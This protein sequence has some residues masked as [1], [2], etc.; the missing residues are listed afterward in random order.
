[1]IKSDQDYP[2]NAKSDCKAVMLLFSSN[3][4]YIVMTFFVLTLILITNDLNI[5][6][7][8]KKMLKKNEHRKYSVMV[9]ENNNDKVDEKLKEAP[10][11][12]P[13]MIVG[14]LDALD[15]YEIPYQAFSVLAEKYGKIIKLQL[16]SVPSMV[17]NGMENIKEVLV[18]KGQHF[19][20]RPNFKRY[21]MLFTLAFCDWSEVQRTRRDM[22]IPHTFPRKFSMNFNR[23]SDITMEHLQQLTV[24]IK[25]S[26]KE[27]KSVSV[28]PLVVSTCANIFTEYFTSRNFDRD[29]EKFQKLIT[30]FDKIFWEV[31]QGYASDFLPFLLPLRRNQMKQMEQWSHE[32]RN[33][34]NEN[35]ITDRFESW[36][37]GDEPNDY[38]DS[39][40][41]HVKQKL[42][43]RFEWET[44]REEIKLRNSNSLTK[45][46]IFIKALFALE[47]IIGGHSAVA[48]FVVKV[49]AFIAK[50]KEV[51]KN[52]QEEVDKLLN[53]RSEHSVLIADRNK[54][55][56]TE[57]VIMESLRIVTSPIVPHVANQDSSI[58]G[59]SVKAGTLIFLNNYDLNMSPSLWNEPEKFE[60]KRFIVDGRLVKPDHFI[61]FGVGR[62]SC[63]GYKMVQFLSFSIVANL[64]K[65]F[66]I[67]PLCN[68]DEIKVPV[69]SLAMSENP[70]Q[71]AF[72]LRT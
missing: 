17:I 12:K 29:N 18:S 30:N 39:L 66:D 41:D 52:I 13:K 40:I 7:M 62:R 70:Y 60:P 20:S 51:Q 42:Q 47:D 11:P 5:S 15:G 69:G 44:V 32:I 63:M 21:H 24:E 45:F 34:I 8:R 25:S 3:T 61:P 50:H 6:V 22:L 54:L 2:T 64:L 9:D 59:Y 16:G 56:Y 27:L 26:M 65:E 37:V 72:N 4:L 14:N 10:G 57:A 48:N 58:D 49:L 53:E 38:I 36:N 1:M 28:K 43:P 35:I 31:N 55:I 68:E 71:F 67:S 23:F 46:I 19:D 33:F